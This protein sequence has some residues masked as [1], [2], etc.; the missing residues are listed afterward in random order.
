[1]KGSFAESFTRSRSS[2]WD[3]ND[4]SI[5]K[6]LDE[7]DNS[8][9]LPRWEPSFMKDIL[10]RTKMQKKTPWEGTNLLEGDKIDLSWHP[11]GFRI[12]NASIEK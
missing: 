7:N 10:L 12:T 8:Y 1:M 9:V 6:D 4:T 2:V 5:F 11:E 3:E